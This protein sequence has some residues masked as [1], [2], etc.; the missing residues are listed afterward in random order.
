M[1]DMEEF[2]DDPDL[3]SSRPY[4]PFFILAGAVIAFFCLTT[5]FLRFWCHSKCFVRRYLQNAFTHSP[6]GR[7]HVLDSYHRSRNLLPRRRS[8]KDYIQPPPYSELPPSYEEVFSVHSFCER[9][10]V[11]D[12]INYKLHLDSASCET[13]S[14]YNDARND[15]V[16]DLCV[17]HY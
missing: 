16:Q 12:S 15:V 2:P 14:V 6:T 10:Q 9:S 13:A 3:S 4:L 1:N 7:F 5:V 11:S 8:L 17:V